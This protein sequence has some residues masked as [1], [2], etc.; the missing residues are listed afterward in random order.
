MRAYEVKKLT[1]KS[2]FVFVKKTKAN[3]DSNIFKK[4]F[5]NI[6]REVLHEKIDKRV[7]NMFAAR[8]G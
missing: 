3:F 4:L 7:E 2:L 6:P 5:I 1:N 8:C